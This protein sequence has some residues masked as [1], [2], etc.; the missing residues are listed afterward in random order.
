[1]HFED[2]KVAVAVVIVDGNKVLLTRRIYNPNQGQW[3]LPAGFMNAHELP[4]EAARR[5]CRE[6]TGLEVEIDS[7]LDIISGREHARGADM[8]IVYRAQITSGE[9]KAGDD[10]SEVGYFDLNR[11]PP[12]AFQATHQVVEMLRKE[13]GRSNVLPSPDSDHL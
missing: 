7:L 5:E 12:L 6:E 4:Q 1:M 9:L 11:L 2:P 13:N 10:A 8:V 3:T